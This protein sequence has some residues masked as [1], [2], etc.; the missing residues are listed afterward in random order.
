MQSLAR[1]ELGIADNTPVPV[2]DDIG[3]NYPKEYLW[4]RWLEYRRFGT[5]PNGEPR[6]NQ[7]KTLQDDFDMLNLLLNHWITRERPRNGG[8]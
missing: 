1:A 6:D 4:P 8:R 2:P 7:R 5:Y 3:L